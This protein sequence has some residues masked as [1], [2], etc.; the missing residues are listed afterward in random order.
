MVAGLTSTISPAI[1]TPPCLQAALR[2]DRVVIRELRAGGAGVIG[3]DAQQ[4]THREASDDVPLDPAVAARDD[5]VL[6]VCAREQEAVGH[7]AVD[8]A[9]DAVAKIALLPLRSAVAAHGHPPGVDDRPAF[10]GLVTDDGR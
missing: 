9:H 7:L 4:S 3:Q 5:P 1:E 8:V 6:L 10:L 2:A